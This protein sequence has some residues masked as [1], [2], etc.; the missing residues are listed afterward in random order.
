[1]IKALVALILFLLVITTGDG[2][3]LKD[4]EPFDISNN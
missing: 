2:Y 4:N 1:M 3:D